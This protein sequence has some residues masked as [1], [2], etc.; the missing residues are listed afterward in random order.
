MTKLGRIPLFQLL[1]FR[2]FGTQCLGRLATRLGVCL[3]T[4]ALTAC[5]IRFNN[6]V[7][8]VFPATAAS[9]NPSTGSSPSSSPSPGI[10]PSPSIFTNG[11][12]GSWTT[13]SSTG[14]PSARSEYTAVWTGSKMVVWGGDTASGTT[15]TG[16]IYDPVS[17]SW[18]STDTTSAGLPAARK[19]LPGGL[20]F[21]GKLWIYGPDNGG[22]LNLETNTW[23][24]DYFKFRSMGNPNQPSSRKDFAMVWT[25]SQL[26]VWGGV[27][28]VS[29]TSHLNT[30]ASYDPYTND[31]TLLAGAGAP[32]ARAGSA[33][34]WTG[35]DLLIFGG[36]NATSVLGDGAKYNPATLTWSA[37]SATNAPAARK[38]ALTAWSGRELLVFGGA[39]F[40]DAPLR[41]AA[42]YNPL[43]D[44][45]RSISDPGAERPTHAYGTVQ[46]TGSH[47]LFFGG[48]EGFSG[49][50]IQMSTP[51][52]ILYDPYA[53][54]W[55]ASSSS[56]I[57]APSS[58]AKPNSVWTGSQLL[59][60]GGVDS[61]LNNLGTGAAFDPNPTTPPAPAAQWSALPSTSAPATRAGAVA[62]WTGSKAIVMGG[63]DNSIGVFDPITNT[64]QTI[65]TACSNPSDPMNP[66][67][68]QQHIGMSAVWTGREAIFW[69]GEDLSTPGTYFDFGY[70]IRLTASGVD[71]VYLPTAANAPSARRD[72]TATWTGKFMF[73]WGGKGAAALDTGALFNP[74]ASSWTAI[75]IGVQTNGPSARYGHTA[76]WTGTHVLVFGGYGGATALQ[77]GGYYS[78]PN[79]SG[80]Q[81][82]SIFITSPAD[83]RL[84][85]SAVWTGR[86]MYVYGGQDTVAGA[87]YRSDFWRLSPNPAD[88]VNG[89]TW[90]QIAVPGIFPDPDRANAA[91]HW[92][93][94]DIILWGGTASTSRGFGLIYRPQVGFIWFDGSA[95]GQQSSG[96][97]FGNSVWTGKHILFFDEVAGGNPTGFTSLRPY[98]D[99]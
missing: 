40:N 46:W 54:T 5:T 79:H 26:L 93:G 63:S 72:H 22:V 9:T 59:V 47:F 58:R 41:S 30:G 81:N 92:T 16:G 7:A 15:N 98:G 21:D 1:R 49:G 18:V 67:S 76:V 60:W 97:A 23:S 14:A 51:Q 86:E 11:A 38:D 12:V 52:A 78:P 3:A 66:V 36:V 73:I 85:H 37:I 74:E 70:R 56:A 61:N 71:C 45:W 55:A 69:G 25:G 91:L 88:S 83:P 35:S 84:N 13:L 20:F 65:N 90:T 57:Q 75:P 8:N 89:G 2:E 24:T 27:D 50:A 4:L 87:T 42:L 6:P 53:A 48:A 43:T 19:T 94:R 32:T 33:Y 99:F 77:S 80:S 95:P 39:D 31:W 44:S 64:W 62:V 34:A 68:I 10:S 82:W 28:P 29:P 17:G 96:R